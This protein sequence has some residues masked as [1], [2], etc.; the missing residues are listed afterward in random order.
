MK[1]IYAWVP[2]FRDLARNIDEGGETYLAEAA[3][4]VAWRNDE[5]KQ[6]LLNYGDENI[7]PFSF[8]YSLAQRSR[9]AG[10]RERVFPSIKSLLQN[11]AGSGN[12]CGER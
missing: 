10:N 8:F 2:W 1:E 12:F 7:D 6:P 3:R 4:K 9:D 5:K 11:S